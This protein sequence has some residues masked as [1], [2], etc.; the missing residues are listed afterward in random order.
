MLWPWFV[1]SVCTATILRAISLGCQLSDSDLAVRAVRAATNKVCH[2]R[3]P[4]SL[5][6]DLRDDIGEDAWREVPSR[7]ELA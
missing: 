5:G 4:L 6:V 2:G 1:R 3:A 7:V